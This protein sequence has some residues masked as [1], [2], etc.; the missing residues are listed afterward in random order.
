MSEIIV[1][2]SESIYQTQG[3]IE[4]G[5]FHGR[6]HFS[7]DEY[8]DPDYMQFGTLRVF[9]DDTLSPGAVWPLHPHK[10]IEVVTYCAEGEFRHADERGKGGILKKG[11]VQHTT[12]GKG[13]MHSEINNS[14][15]KPMR[16]I[17][18]WFFPSVHGL[19]PSVEQRKV[20]KNERTDRILP[21]VSMRH[22]DALF[23]HSDAEVH[24]CFLK[25]G[26][27]VEHNIK[28]DRGVY[29]YVLEGKGLE[30]NGN[31]IQALGALKAT[32]VLTLHITAIG[33]SELLIVDVLF[34]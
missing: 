7:F 2:P 31:N 4:N 8:N 5:T 33:D 17:Q 22:R 28:K 15:A 30:V 29:L 18:M 10:E 24:S 13:M 9:N 20:E 27:K 14:E 26:N 16:F 3:K 11:W 21:I 1:R 19:T 25:K 34:S 32:G 12:V 23:I 6:W